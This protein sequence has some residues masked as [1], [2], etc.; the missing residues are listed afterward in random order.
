M[1]TSHPKTEAPKWVIVDAEGQNLGRMAA[2]IATILRGKHKASFSPHLLCGDH[3]IVIN[4]AKIDLHP[5]K[6]RRRSYIR[7]TGR[8]G[9]LKVRSL[10]WM[11]ERRPT[12]VVEKAVK[13][14]LPHNKLRN[15]MLKRL[16]VY[17]D[18]EH[19]HEAQKPVPLS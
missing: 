12:E 16:H 4:A 6:F 17:A 7:H 9:H 19:T 18:A 8:I 1:K 15:G 13:G 3:V 11:M 14:M 5:T 10:K 2:S